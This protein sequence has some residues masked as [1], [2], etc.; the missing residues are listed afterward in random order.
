MK[1]CMRLR[2][3]HYF[4]RM[5]LLTGATGLVGSHIL[6][7]ILK[8]GGKVRALKRDGSDVSRLVQQ[9]SHYTDEPQA[10]LDKV[11]WFDA[12]ILDQ[13]RLREAFSGITE[14]IH[15]AAVVSFARQDR[16][17]L[18]ASN[19]EGTANLVNLSLEFGIRKFGYI[20]SVAALGHE[21]GDVAI[22][23][24]TGW[25]DSSGSTHYGISK[26]R[27]EMEV[28]RAAEEGLDIVIV[29]PSTIIGPGEW[30]RGSTALVYRLWKGMRTYTLGTTGYV[31]VRDVADVILDLMASDIRNDRFLLS[32]ADLSYLELFTSVNKAFG[33]PAPSLRVNRLMAA[34]A[35]RLEALRC[36]FTGAT[37]MMTRETA[38]KA[39]SSVRF[40][41]T[42]I[43]RTTGF[44]YRDIEDAIRHTCDCLL[45]DLGPR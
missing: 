16:D 35:W 42:K 10:L 28:W 44:Q 17:A 26:H 8:E 32:G 39:F 2:R 12:D 13:Q 27:A 43:T 1:R 40:D 15:A 30:G 29:N 25:N 31:D 19:V 14:V 18:Y 41:G 36:V 20:S 4:C 7:R 23:E 5:I 3:F 37:P 38:Q 22:S 33:R 45:R 21:E 6:L 34:V 24:D 9:F 11:E